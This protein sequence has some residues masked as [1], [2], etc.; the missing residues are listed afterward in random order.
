MIESSSTE[1]RIR[2]VEE[3]LKFCEELLS[4]EARMNLAKRILEELMRQIRKIPLNE[5]PESSR[6]KVSNMELRIRILYHRANA[7]LSLQEE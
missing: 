3:D 5:L 4:K 6:S 2:E 1:K 7:L